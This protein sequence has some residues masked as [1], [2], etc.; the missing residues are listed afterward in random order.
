MREMSTT[1]YLDYVNLGYFEPNNFTNPMEIDAK[2]YND[3]DACC[4]ELY[5]DL[6]EVYKDKPE[7]FTA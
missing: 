4:E 7:L 3:P 5:L 2:D 1:C 6:L